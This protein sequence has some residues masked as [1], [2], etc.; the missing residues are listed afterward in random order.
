[1]AVCWVRFLNNEPSTIAAS[2][3]LAGGVSVH[4]ASGGAL[5]VGLAAGIV[6]LY[7]VPFLAAFEN[8]IGLLIIGKSRCTKPGS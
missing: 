3:T 6:F 4:Q 5:L 7:A 1:M 2:D 8:I